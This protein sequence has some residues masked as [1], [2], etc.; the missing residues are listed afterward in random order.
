M[1]RKFEVGDEIWYQGRGARANERDGRYDGV[2]V[3][4][5]PDGGLV[6]NH[7]TLG[8]CIRPEEAHHTNALVQLAREL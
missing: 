4:I 7:V 3:W 8:S 5:R 6:I 1:S 2:V